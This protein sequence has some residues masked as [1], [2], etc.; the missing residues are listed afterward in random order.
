MSLDQS[1]SDHEI[2]FIQES[3]LR[4]AMNRLAE[5]EHVIRLNGVENEVV[6]RVVSAQETL[7]MTIIM[8]GK[9][10]I[11]LIKSIA[12]NDGSS[13]RVPPKLDAFQLF[14]DGSKVMLHGSGATLSLDHLSRL[15]QIFY[16]SPQ[17]TPV[18]EDLPPRRA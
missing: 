10:D 6:T 1:S 13:Q 8:K 9:P 14:P 2:S 7:T 3:L 18:H 16:A 15:F 12:Q 5:G 11:V 4:S 17:R